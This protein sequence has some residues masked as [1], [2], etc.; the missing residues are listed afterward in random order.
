MAWTLGGVTIHPDDKQ[1]TRQVD[2]NY[3]IQDVLDAT[4]EVASWYGGKSPRINLN[5][6]LFGDENG[7]TGESQLETAVLTNAD[8]SLVSDIG[9]VGNVRILSLKATR[10]Q[11]LN[12]TGESWD[13]ATSL[14]K[15]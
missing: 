2:A 13:C 12:H 1:Y 9:T 15:V 6:V 7:G 8:V 14:V 5:F 10:R 4:T 3:A 11:A